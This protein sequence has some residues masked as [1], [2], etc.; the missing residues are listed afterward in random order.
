MIVGMSAA[1]S[2]SASAL[3][4]DGSGTYSYDPSTGTVTASGTV[5]AG[6]P[7]ANGSFSSTTDCSNNTGTLTLTDGNEGHDQLNQTLTNVSCAGGAEPENYTITGGTGRFTGATGTGTSAVTTSGGLSG[8]FS[9]HASGT[10]F[11][12]QEISFTSTPP[13]Q[14]AVNQPYTVSAT[15]GDSGNP[16][17]FKVDDFSDFNVCSISGSTVSFSRPGTCLIDADQAGDDTY[18]A[19]PQKQQSLGVKYGQSISFTSTPPAQP[20]VGGSYTVT[21]GPRGGS[22]NYEYLSVDPASDNG[23]C[24]VPDPAPDPVPYNRYVSFDGPGLCVLD[25]NQDGDDRY[26]AAPQKQQ[27]LTVTK[28]AQAISFASTPP[29]HPTVG[30]SYDVSAT[31]GDS[32]NPVTFRIDSSSA[33]GACLLNGST[34]SFTGTGTCVIDADQA[35]NGTYDAAPQKQQSLTIKTPA[36]S[37]LSTHPGSPGQ[38]STPS[39]FGSAVS[40]STVNVYDNSSCTGAPVASGSQSVFADGLRVSAAV[41]DGSTTSYYAT[42]TAHHGTT[43]DCSTSHAVYTQDSV[44]PAAPTGLSTDPGSP[45]QSSTPKVKGTAEAGSTVLVW[46]N[47]SCDGAGTVATGSAADFQ[48]P[49]LTVAAVADGSTTTFSA[50]ATDQAGNTSDCST[51][52]AVYTQDSVKPA[53][54]TG[55]STDPASPGATSTPKVTGTAE[56]GSTVL[57]WNDAFCTGSGIVAFGSAADFEATGLTLVPVVDGSTTTFSAEATDQAGNRS[58]C[59]TSTATYLQRST[60]YGLSTDPSSPGASLTPAVKGSLPGDYGYAYIGVYNNATCSGDPSAVGTAAT[61]TGSGIPVGVAAG[62][63]T[64]FSVAGDNDSN[65]FN[66]GRSE[67]STDTVTYTQRPATPPATD[68]VAPSTSDDVPASAQNH[69]VSVTLTATDNP[70]G[71]GVDKTYYTTGTSPA[72]PTTTSSS[73]YDAAHKP[74]LNDG[75]K[76]KYFSTDRAGNSE[77]VKTSG[78]ARVTRGAG[79]TT[80]PTVVV[81]TSPVGAPPGQDGFFNAADL[82]VAGGKTTVHVSASDTSHVTKLSCTDNHHPVVLAGESGS[83][84]RTGSFAL[85][86]DGTHGVSCN[87]T[88]GAAPPNTG[89]AAASRPTATVR[90]D[91]SAPTAGTSALAVFQTE[92]GLTVGWSGSDSGSGVGSFDVRQR[93]AVSNSSRFGAFA[94]F[95]ARVR[96]TR[97]RFAGMPGSTVCFSTRARDRAGNVSAY[98]VARCTAFPLDDRALHRRGRWT[99]IRN[100]GFY[101]GALLKSTTIGSTLTSPVLTG[102]RLALLVSTGPHGGTIEVKWHGHTQTISLDS[103]HTENRHLIALPGFSGTGRLLIRVSGPGT[104]AIDGLG[105][106]KQ[107]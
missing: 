15:G 84:P 24:S 21:T 43:S 13:A 39:V 12:G 14:P 74:T 16:V 55:L 93:K 70:G 58:D 79:D 100:R 9:F 37:G 29:E 73:V 34:V 36:P 103:A 63:T 6:A 77:S 32:G 56:A 81:S 65:D 46:D 50:E 17:T 57:V 99:R 104:T 31:G 94:G 42:A 90:I 20:H 105:V 89:A 47:A 91:A 75:Q 86:S 72:D 8:T 18:A 54:P 60:P 59:S 92:R 69:P 27:M 82:A 98:S 38:S 51:S 66:D 40:D 97:A 62:S 88:D 23:A 45:G 61:F 4:G 48:D 2:A 71:S 35:G 96:S 3:T 33:S 76:I 30:G 53:A 19:A 22:D 78:A 83:D 101:S 102:G 87:A 80:P 7:I 107:P 1:S 85:S 95:R 64:T 44:K 68:S 67:C 28:T 5:T 10:Y 52:H 26:Y 106:W 41:A 11:L 49:G 25:L